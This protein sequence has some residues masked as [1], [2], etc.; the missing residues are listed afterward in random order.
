MRVS[1]ETGEFG[2]RA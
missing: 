2:G 1:T